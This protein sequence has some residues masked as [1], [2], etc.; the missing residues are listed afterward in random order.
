MLVVVSNLKG[1]VSKTTTAIAVSEMGCRRFDRPSLLVDADPAGSAFR[2]H[3]LAGDGLTSICVPLPTPDLE[4]R[5]EGIGAGGYRLCVIDTGARL[6]ILRAAFALA[7]VV[8]CP[9]R[10]A[11]ADIDR[12]WT[13]LDLA[14]EVPVP[15]LTVLV[16]TRVGTLSLAA[17]QEAL[18]T[19]K[20]K[21]ACVT[22]P[23]R[24]SVARAFGAPVTGALADFG[25]ALLSEV[26]AMKGKR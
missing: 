12:L 24:E 14:A 1:G 6:D 23:M 16:M 13:T 26:L 3:E 15:A 7:D 25:K 8:I 11:L 5:L 4:R 20:V 10:P 18:K 21:T 22:L 2:W 19:A 9:T 17:A